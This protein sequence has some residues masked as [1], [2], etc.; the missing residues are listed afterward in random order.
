MAWYRQKGCAHWALVALSLPSWSD[1]LSWGGKTGLNRVYLP[2]FVLSP[3]LMP[4]LQLLQDETSLFFP[5]LS[6]LAAENNI[7]ST[8]SLFV[9]SER[10]GV[11]LHGAISFS[12]IP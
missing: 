7:R 9:H 3:T 11:G 4:L 6:A 1:S 10:F 12:L 2:G 8:F 5:N